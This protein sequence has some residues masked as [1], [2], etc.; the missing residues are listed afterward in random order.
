MNQE[1][2]QSQLKVISNISRT[3]NINISLPQTKEEANLIIDKLKPKLAD[4][5]AHK[6]KTIDYYIGHQSNESIEHLN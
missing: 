6:G 4:Y 2:K 1:P 5:I 3:L